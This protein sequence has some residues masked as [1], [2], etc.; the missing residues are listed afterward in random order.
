MPSANV[1]ANEMLV[2]GL[3]TEFTETYSRVIKQ[4]EPMLTKVMELGIPSNKLSEVYGYF[5]S[6]PHWK[7]WQRGD[8][9]PR[10]GFRARNFIVQNYDWAVSIDWHE[11]DEQDDQSLSLVQRVREAATGVAILAERIFFQILT[12]ATDPN[13]LPA[14]PNAPDGSALFATTANGSARFG[15]SSGNLLT[16]TGVASTSAIQTDL[17]TAWSQF[18]K[19]QDTEGQPLWPAETLNRGVVILY[20][21]A[22]EQAFR[23]AFAQMFIQGSSAAPSNVILDTRM[24]IELWN[25][26]RITDND[27]FV[28][29]ANAPKKAIFQQVRQAPRDMMAD[30]QN[31]DFTRATKIKSMQFDAR[32]GFGVSLPLAAIK[33]NN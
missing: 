18:R 5:E 29:M 3:R 8:D 1:A 7:R 15:A 10:A 30:M 17:F 11:N 27:W 16:G 22:N 28:F 23:Q 33:V 21:S 24:N 19:F 32:Y 20:G 12:G 25:S 26:P 6:V 2:R 9:I 4:A 14:V 13:L 31:S